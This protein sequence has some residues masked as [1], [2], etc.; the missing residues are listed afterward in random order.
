MKT[1]TTTVT[2]AGAAG[3]SSPARW[4][5]WC[6]C[7]AAARTAP[8]GTTSSSTTSACRTATWRSSR[9][10][11]Q[12]VAG[13]SLSTLLTRSTLKVSQLGLTDQGTITQTISKGSVN[14]A[15]AL[16]DTLQAA[17]RPVPRAVDGADDVAGPDRQVPERAWSRRRTASRRSRFRRLTRPARCRPA[18]DPD[19]CAPASAF[20][21]PASALPA[22]AAGYAARHPRDDADRQAVGQGHPHGHGQEARPRRPGEQHDHAVPGRWAA[23]RRRRRLSP[24]GRPSC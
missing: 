8:G 16:I 4:C 5:C 15:K 14:D 7:S 20:G 18:P 17:V 10:T 19:S 1:T 9:G 2:G 24:A 6:C 11:N 22:R 12:S 23:S 13:I 21:I 3:R